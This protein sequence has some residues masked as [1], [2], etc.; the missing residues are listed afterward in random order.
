[1]AVLLADQRN[2]SGIRRAEKK[3]VV[4]RCFVLFFQESAYP[5][6]RFFYLR[7]RILLNYAVNDQRVGKMGFV[8]WKNG[9]FSLDVPDKYLKRLR[10]IPSRGAL[11]GRSSLLAAI[12]PDAVTVINAKGKIEADVL[13]APVPY[14]LSA[15]ES[16]ALLPPGFVE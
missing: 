3:D 11:S 12:E 10:F 13:I 8:L 6:F 7:E 16:R 4:Q 15:G 14:N 2:T 5:C 1:M 9:N